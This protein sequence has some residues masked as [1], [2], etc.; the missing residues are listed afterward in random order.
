MKVNREQR[1]HSLIATHSLLERKFNSI[2]F[3]WEIYTNNPTDIKSW[4]LRIVRLLW[5]QNL[6]HI[7]LYDWLLVFLPLKINISDVVLSEYK[8]QRSSEITLREVRK[9]LIQWIYRPVTSEYLY[10][11]SLDHLINQ[12]GHS[13]L[14]F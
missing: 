2:D 14:F 1:L 11:L 3:S 6:V 13:N 9:L 4:F 10:F 5:Y 8:P 7:W 12:A